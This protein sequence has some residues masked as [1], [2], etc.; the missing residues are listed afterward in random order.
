MP[1]LLDSKMNNTNGFTVIEL[2]AVVAIVSI[3][4]VVALAAYSDYAV[5]GKVAEAMGFAAEAK[6]KVSE[7]YYINKDMPLSNSEAGL[8]APAEYEDRYE[9]IRTLELST[10]DPY[11]II[12]ITFKLPGT[13]ADYKRLQL[14][15]TTTDGI[16]YWRC[17]PPIDNGIDTNQVPA[18]CRG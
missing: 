13:K 9:F 12:T 15:P 16:I 4:A 18:N 5:R 2:M 10:S 3:L 7:Y 1:Y 17:S 8:P 6:T 14:T 11:G